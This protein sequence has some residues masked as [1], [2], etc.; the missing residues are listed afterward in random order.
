[1]R[2]TRLL[3]CL[4]F[5]ISTKVLATACP[6]GS[7]FEPGNDTWQGWG[8]SHGNTRF[9]SILTNPISSATLP[10]LTLKWAYGFKDVRSVIGNPALSGNRIFIG[11]ENGKVYSLD[12]DSGCEDWIFQAD[13]G[14][15]TMPLIEEIDGRWL[16]FFW[17]S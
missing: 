1:M 14:V 11:D 7:G 4:F 16:V 5:T 12:R 17:G 2:K 15:R 10:R 8:G 13:N 3:L 6:A 9:N